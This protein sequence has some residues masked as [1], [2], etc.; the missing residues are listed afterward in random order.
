MGKIFGRSKRAES[1]PNSRDGF[2]ALADAYSDPYVQARVG[3]SE[4]AREIAELARGI[5]RMF[6]DPRLISNPYARSIVESDPGMREALVELAK[7][8]RKL[9]QDAQPRRR[10][11]FSFLR[12]G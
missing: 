12:R 7:S 11:W 8:A 6:N 3:D 10:R 4:K 9:Q 2:A 5:S 1:E